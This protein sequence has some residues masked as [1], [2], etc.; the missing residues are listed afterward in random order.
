VFN[1]VMLTG[2]AS[3]AGRLLRTSQPAVTKLLALAEAEAGIRLFERDRGRLVPTSEAQTLFALSRKAFSALDDVRQLARNLRERRAGR[4]RVA[5]IPALSLGVL[6]RAVQ[7]FL[8]SHPGT[9]CEVATHHT[10]EIVQNLLHHELD[11]GFVFNAPPHE[12]IRTEAIAHAQMVVVATDPGLSEPL[13]LKDL[14]DRSFIGLDPADPLGRLLQSACQKGGLE[15]RV[16]VR[17]QTYHTA[18]LMARA[19]VGVAIIDRY[20]ALAAQ[21]GIVMRE[22]DPPISFTL[23]ALTARSRQTG[24]LVD[25]FV[26]CLKVAEREISRSTA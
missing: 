25:Q 13:S 11:V 1:T 21:E 20:T 23:H 18:L 6:P 4:I 10:H 2:S 22:L 9:G 16:V 12:A 19:R 14:A 26:T 24:H 5:T 15:P 3:A 8:A 7:C 17:V